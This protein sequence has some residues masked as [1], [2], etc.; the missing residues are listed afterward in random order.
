[1][2]DAPTLPARDWHPETLAWWAA[3]WASPMARQYL[4][5]DHPA[6][7]RLALLVE[8]FQ[9]ADDPALR[10]SLAG[11]IRLEQQAFGLTPFD[12]RR[13]PRDSESW[14]PTG[15][16]ALCEWCGEPFPAVR[17]GRFC[18]PAHRSA[19]RREREGER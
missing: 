15:E 4:R 2:A 19:A 3:V 14:W 8:D 11:E 12:R 13:L 5:A 6:L 1:M 17:G 10:S 18:S 16:P 7:F 9:R